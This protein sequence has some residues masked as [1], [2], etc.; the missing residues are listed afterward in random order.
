MRPMAMRVLLV[1][2]SSL[3]LCGCTGGDGLRQVS[4]DDTATAQPSDAS[5]VPEEF[6]AACG[7]PGSK[8]VT[9]RLEVTIKHADCDLTGVTIVNQD[10]GGV[11]PEPGV[12]FATEGVTIEVDENTGD[13]SFTAEAEVG[14]A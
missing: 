4:A 1:L 10:R 2:V 13:V 12:G 8:V 11:V 7:K 3:A 5:A 9:E 6:R 14:N